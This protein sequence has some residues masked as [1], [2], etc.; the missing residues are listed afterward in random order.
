MKADDGDPGG[1][2]Q[3][4]EDERA[5]DAPAADSTLAFG[6]NVELGNTITKT[7]TLSTDNGNSSRYAG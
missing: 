3:C 5:R 4:A 7:T 1:D 2:H 6:G